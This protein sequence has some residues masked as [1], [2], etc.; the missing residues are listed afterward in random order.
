M[1]TK[2]AFSASISGWVTVLSLM[3][4][5]CPCSLRAQNSSASYTFLVASGFLCDTGDSGNCPAVAKSANGDSYEISGA[6]AFDLY[7]KSVEAAGTFNHRSRN[8]NVLETGVWTASNLISFHSYG[9]APAALMRRGQAFGLPQIAPK[10][11]AVRSGGM[12]T[13][14]LAIFRV[15]LATVS[16]TTETAVLQ[17]NCALGD[18]PREGSVEGILI[19]LD[20]DNSEYSEESSERVMFLALRHELRTPTEKPQQNPQLNLK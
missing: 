3:P 13:G 11:L 7:N 4:L 8:G 1:P 5:A 19:T 20:R 16:G 9:I 2:R 10:R 18:V 14:G 6:G 12:P 17:V 15:I